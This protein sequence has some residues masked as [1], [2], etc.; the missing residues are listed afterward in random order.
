MEAIQYMLNIF[1]DCD[2][3]DDLQKGMDKLIVG[4]VTL[5]G[6]LVYQCMC[7]IFII[8][9]CMS[10]QFFKMRSS[11]ICLLPIELD[12]PPPIPQLYLKWGNQVKIRFSRSC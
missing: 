11:Q 4:A 7:Q 10:F 9:E 8:H 2:T 5:A 3:I 1:Q 12:P 6:T